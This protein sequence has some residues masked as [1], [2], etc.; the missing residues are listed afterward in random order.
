MAPAPV[1]DRINSLLEDNGQMLINER[2]L[3]DG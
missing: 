1:L 3:V 2:G